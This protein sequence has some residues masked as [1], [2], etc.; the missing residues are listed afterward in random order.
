MLKFTGS[1]DIKHFVK[2]VF[3]EQGRMTGQVVVDIPAGRGVISNVLMELGADVRSYDLFPE[4]FDVAGIDC[5]EADLTSQLPI[6]DG[7]ADVVLCQEGIEHIPDQISMLRELNRITKLGG[8]LIITTPN[9]SHLR[10]RFSYFLTESE[11][12]KRM[13]PNELDAVWHAESGKRY[14]GHIFLINIQKLRVLCEISGFRIKRVNKVK[15]S[16]G[17]LFLSFWYPLIFLVNSW[18][19]I[20][21]ISKS[22]GL[23]RDE[24]KRVYGEIFKLNVHPTILFGRH[25]FLELEK[26]SE[27]TDMEIHVNERRS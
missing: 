7:I 4:F 27:S 11:L 18:S 20:K 21:N 14:Y 15:A 10:A 13:P 16:L 1:S 9:I 5:A 22:D 19:Y 3:T 25:L 26:V 12:W 24:K 23:D 2:Q 6:E 8:K 17:S